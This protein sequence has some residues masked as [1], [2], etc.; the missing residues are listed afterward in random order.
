MADTSATLQGLHAAGHKTYQ[1][2][3]SLARPIALAA[4]GDMVRDLKAFQEEA[5]LWSRQ[6]KASRDRFYF[7][8]A[9]TMQDILRIQELVTADAMPLQVSEAFPSKKAPAPAPAAVAEA[10]EKDEKDEEE[11]EH[12]GGEE[13]KFQGAPHF[14]ERD[15]DDDE[16][17]DEKEKKEEGT[18][19]LAPESPAPRSTVAAASPLEELTAMLYAVSSAVAEAEVPATADRLRARLDAREELLEAL[20]QELETL[21]GGSSGP[22]VRAIPPPG[23]DATN[24]AGIFDQPSNFMHVWVCSF[25]QLTHASTPMYVC[26]LFHPHPRRHAH[27]DRCQLQARTAALCDGHGSAGACD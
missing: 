10:Q 19:A 16:E 13:E 24:R 5:D 20:G 9:F 7:L 23:A 2:S 17:E 21:F 22:V 3:F 1:A 18:N 15:N 27:S 8:N 11:G 26:W 4:F 12:K 25:V 14:E 6:V